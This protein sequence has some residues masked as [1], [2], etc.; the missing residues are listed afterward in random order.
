MLDLGGDCRMEQLRPRVQQ[1]VDQLV[2]DVLDHPP[3]VDFHAAASFPLP[4]QVICE[5]LGVPF[6]DREQ[7]GRWSD[8]AADLTDAVANASSPLKT[9]CPTCSPLR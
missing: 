9:S 5:L 2:D 8:D 4:V 6:E 3:P 7:F 1:L